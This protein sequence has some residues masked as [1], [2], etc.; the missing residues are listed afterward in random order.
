LP[1]VVGGNKRT[2][3][4]KQTNGWI[5]EK[6]GNA[7]LRQCWTKRAQQNLFALALENKAGDQDV[8]SGSGSCARGDVGKLGTGG[9]SW[10]RSKQCS[11]PVKAIRRQ[12]I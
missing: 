1:I 10:R 9:G 5:S 11:R 6:T 4:I 7:E 2:I 3:G 12:A 8:V